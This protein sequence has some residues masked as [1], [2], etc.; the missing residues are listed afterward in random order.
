MEKLHRILTAKLFEHYSFA[1]MIAAYF[2][3]IALVRTSGLH[4]MN[5]IAVI[6]FVMCLLFYSKL[7]QME[8]DGKIPHKWPFYVLPPVIGLFFTLT[9]L[10]GCYHVMTEDLENR[11]FRILISIAV[12]IGLMLLFSGVVLFV[13][14]WIA[15]YKEHFTGKEGVAR[16]V[17]PAKVLPTATFVLS[18]LMD[19]PLFLYEYP[20]I[21]TPDSVNQLEQVV[22][23]IPYS[24]HHPWLHT[25]TIGLFYKLGFWI[26]GD[27]NSSLAFFTLFQMLIMSLA[28][29]YAVRTVQ[30]YTGRSL[31]PIVSMLLFLLLPYH[32]TMSVIIWKDVL[33]SA[34]V[35]L[36]C[37]S[38]Y[39]VLI[40]E[41]KCSVWIRILAVV[42]GF[43]MCLY[44]SNGIYAF[45]LTT[46]AICVFFFRKWKQFV[47]ILLPIL[48]A[49]LIVR[50]PIM[51]LNHVTQPDFVESLSIPLQEIANVI[52]SG[53]EL[54]PEEEELLSHIMDLNHVSELY[55]PTIADPI[56][57]LVRANDPEYLETHKAE[58]L[59]LWFLLTYR[60]P[61]EKLDAYI[62]ET[63]G[64]YNPLAVYASADTEG[65]IP[66]DI[67]LYS[68]PKIGGPLVVKTREIYLKLQ[69]IFPLYGILW[70]MGSTLWC[71]LLFLAMAVAGG[72]THG[73]EYQT[74]SVFVAYLPVLA[75]IG[76]L[77][78]ATPVS[79]E[80]RYAYSMFFSFPFL[81][82][83]P[84]FT[85]YDNGGSEKADS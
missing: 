20:G 63:S 65:I 13:M 37:S 60:Y 32:R 43:F 9:Y 4:A 79:T 30:K 40:E 47:P 49:F 41:E 22:G 66:N 72:V 70:S 76:T 68:I 62:N 8:N 56:K 19:L 1:A 61:A 7:T 74:R 3:V 35:L 2:S 55:D 59:K 82:M 42:S 14:A 17:I 11:L 21:M 23:L 45:L 27:P 75:V 83:L 46:A 6:L 53:D 85:I 81:C 69:N 31:Y 39:E 5:V 71:L 48:I 54:T 25:L 18:F 52:A 33:F 50:I 24:N 36:F 58:Y 77:L 80:F 44:R 78:I 26:T 12:A 10:S 38:I 73:K 28:G 15:G 16:K 29:A 34:A 51:N 84:F 57:E 67:G 64:Y